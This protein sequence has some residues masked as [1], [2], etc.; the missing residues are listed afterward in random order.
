MEN[1]KPH[2]GLILTNPQEEGV[3]G[4]H[5]ADG[6]GRRP[7]SSCPCM[8]LSTNTLNSGMSSGI[9]FRT[10]QVSGGA[11]D[12]Y[13]SGVRRVLKLPISISSVEHRR[14]ED[15]ELLC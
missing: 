6:E 3:P 4:D 15:K 8:Q 12:G 9:G 10:E 13:D 14:V 11:G 2:E 7:A 5:T 1:S